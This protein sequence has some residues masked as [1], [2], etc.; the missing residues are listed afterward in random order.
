LSIWNPLRH[1]QE[2]NF[3]RKRKRGAYLFKC[4]SGVIEEWTRGQEK[5]KGRNKV[6]DAFALNHEQELTG[7]KPLM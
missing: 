1:C 7:L 3:V 5:K 4:K 2:K 6:K